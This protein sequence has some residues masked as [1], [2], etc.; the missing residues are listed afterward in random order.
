[1]KFK[2][3]WIGDGKGRVMDIVVDS[4]TSPIKVKDLC[5]GVGGITLGVLYLMRNAFR[6]GA[7][8]HEIAET[9]TLNAL[10]LIVNP[11]EK[12]NN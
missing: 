11:E 4:R 3:G 9:K 8:A 5:I 10:D 2:Q 12:S 6:S 7:E 1:M